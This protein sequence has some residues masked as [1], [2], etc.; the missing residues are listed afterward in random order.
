MD[1][2]VHKIVEAD[3][4]A[5]DRRLR[6][7]PKDADKRAAIVAAAHR[8]FLQRGLEAVK[9]EEIAGEAS[10]SKMTVY[11]NFADKAALFE[12]VVEEQNARIERAFERFPVARGDFATVATEFGTALLTFLL[13]PEIMRFDHILSA[14][15]DRHPGL[16]QRFYRAGPSQMQ[17]TLASTIEAAMHGDELKVGD[18]KRAAEDLIALWLGLAPLRYRFGDLAPLSDAEIASRI[19]HGVSIFMKYYGV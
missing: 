18:A 11:S 15:L 7:R 9:V 8:L 2:R 13:D 6:G 10:V 4:S 16:G 17:G 5:D 14:E 1:L 3:V 12:A 19:H